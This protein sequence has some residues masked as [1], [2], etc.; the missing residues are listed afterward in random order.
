[1][2][3]CEVQWDWSLLLKLGVSIKKK[4]KFYLKIKP[5]FKPKPA[6]D[7]EFLFLERVGGKMKGKESRRQVPFQPPGHFR[8]SIRFQVNS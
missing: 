4:H 7:I 6:L 8:D 3:G 5:D 1:M 2:R